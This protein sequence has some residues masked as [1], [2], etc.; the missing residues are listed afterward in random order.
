MVACALACPLAVAKSATKCA[1]DLW[2]PDEGATP[3][4]L[5]VKQKLEMT[6]VVESIT[7]AKAQQLANRAEALANTIRQKMEPHGENPVAEVSHQHKIRFFFHIF[8]GEGERFQKLAIRIVKEQMLSIQS[9]LP[10]SYEVY[11]TTVGTLWDNSSINSSGLNCSTC[12]RGAHLNQGWESVTQQALFEYCHNNPAEQV[13]YIHT[14]GGYHPRKVN[15]KFR[16]FLMKGVTS[17]ECSTMTAK[18]NVCSSRFSPMP[19]PHAPG[20]MWQAKCSYIRKLAPPTFFEQNMSLVSAMGQRPFSKDWAIGSGRYAAEHWVHSHP[21]V[22]PC[23]VYA[24]GYRYAYV[25]EQPQVDGTWVPQLYAGIRFPLIKYAVHAPGSWPKWVQW[26]CR[27]WM[28]LYHKLPTPKEMRKKWKFQ[29]VLTGV[30]LPKVCS[31]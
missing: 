24:G 31:P 2:E 10:N 17:K 9:A 30:D 25:L 18:C 11:F 12:Y 27:E 15:H 5:Q 13:A 1:A 19:H 4:M 20:N 14:K 16:R 29:Q 7:Q 26:R 21:D 23:D 22:E 6:P 28:K 8:K 3:N